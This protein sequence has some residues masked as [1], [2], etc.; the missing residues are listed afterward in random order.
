MASLGFP[1]GDWLGTDSA[2]TTP[3]TTPDTAQGIVTSL[4][5]PGTLYDLNNPNAEIFKMLA[6][7]G[8]AV[9]IFGFDVADRLV[10][11]FDPAG[12]LEKVPDWERALNLVPG[13]QNVGTNRTI[14]QRRQ[15]IVGKLRESGASTLANIRAAVAPVLGYSDPSTLQVLETNRAALTAKH[16]YNDG[17]ATLS[18]TSGNTVTRLINVADAGF[19]AGGVQLV[20]NLTN[21]VSSS[22]KVILT[23]PNG[24]TNYTWQGFSFGFNAGDDTY[25]Y[26]PSTFAAADI[27][28][29]W[30]VA[31]KNVSG[32]TQAW[33]SANLF[34]EGLTNGGTGADIYYW[35]IYVDPSLANSPDFAAAKASMLRVNPAHAAFFIITDIG[36]GG[37]YPDTVSGPHEA[38]PNQCLPA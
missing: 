28:G 37:P 30:T 10:A 16:T 22:W 4:F 5:P 7:F 20:L 18:V 23:A 15:A 35:G 33:S 6:G 9:K 2:V 29:T 1:L 31:V 8:S 21:N 11:E 14:P 12:C 17:N 38:I 19:P 26:A 27:Y 36:N 25:L 3:S 24:S 32:S 34:V 13:T